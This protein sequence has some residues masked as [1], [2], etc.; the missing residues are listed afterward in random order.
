MNTR[1]FFYWRLVL[2]PDNLKQAGIIT[3]QQNTQFVE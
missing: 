1:K 3:I 2:N